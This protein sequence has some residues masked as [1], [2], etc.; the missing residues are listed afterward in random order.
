[1]YDAYNAARPLTLVRD[2]SYWQGYYSVRVGDWLS[3]AGAV[4]L[5]ATRPA[6]A[7]ALCGYVLAHVAAT[8]FLIAEIGAR[9]DDMEAIPALLSAVADEAARR[10][11]TRGK[12]KLPDEPS[13]TMALAALFGPTL[14]PDLNEELMARAIAPEFAE[15]ELDAIVAAPGAIF[16]P[17]DEF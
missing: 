1:V 15:Q 2:P 16:W 17:F 4:Y 11:A 6:E 8:G 5:V 7:H 12:V 3:S 10:G 13:T 9:P 14:Q